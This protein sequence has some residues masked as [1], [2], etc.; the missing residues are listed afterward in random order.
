LREGKQGFA[1]TIDPQHLRGR[2]HRDAVTPLQPAGTGLAQR[3]LASGGRVAGQTGV[4]RGGQRLF[5]KGGGGMLGLTD[6][7]ADRGVGW[8]GGDVGEQLAQPLE[9]I[10]LQSRQ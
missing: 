2:V 9:G 1:R 6:A 10:R 5:Q 7:Q 4:Q 3:G 8:V